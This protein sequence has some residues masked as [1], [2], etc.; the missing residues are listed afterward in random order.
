MNLSPFK[1]ILAF[2]D[3]RNVN[4]VHLHFTQRRPQKRAQAKTHKKESQPQQANLSSYM[5]LVCNL[6]DGRAIDAACPGCSHSR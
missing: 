3:G 5:I 4:G 2:A 6:G 1:I